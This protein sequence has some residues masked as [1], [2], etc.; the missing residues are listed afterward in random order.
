MLKKTGLFAKDIRV[1]YCEDSDFSLRVRQAGF[2]IAFV[3]IAHEHRRSSSTR[4]IPH[5]TLEAIHERNRSR[6]LSRWGQYLEK[7]TLT[8]RIF[9][10]LVSDGWGD[11]FCALPAI[12]QL[13]DDHPTAQITLRVKQQFIACI[14]ENIEN[15]KVEIGDKLSNAEFD[16][17]ELASD[18]AFRLQN[19]AFTE[20]QLLGR[21]IASALGVEFVAERAEAHL[22]QLLARW[23]LPTLPT[24]SKR[25]AVLHADYARAD[26]EGR[27]PLPALFAEAIGVIKK[28]GI[29]VFA[30]GGNN[31]GEDVHEL[32]QKCDVNLLGKTDFRSMLQL[33]AQAELFVGIDS[34][35]VHIAQHFG[36]K[37]FAVF[38]ATLPTA[39]L[40]RWQNTDVFMNWK[41]P[42][43]GCYHQVFKPNA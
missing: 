21:E 34:G 40:F 14:F 3:D 32:A 26:W 8:N 27:G 9:L 19:V 37:T 25:Y 18:R 7:K 17:L 23:N 33:I 36:T 35:P 42:C 10:E 20:T 4:L 1:A 28:R 30:I 11:V 41:L 39:R 5:A 6:L 31:A 2:S 16:A 29:Q 22:K 38:G 43:L 12:L 15:L 24:G 13:R